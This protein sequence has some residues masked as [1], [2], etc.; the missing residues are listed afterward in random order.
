MRRF[1]F[2][3][4]FLGVFLIVGWPW[5]ALCAFA[6]LLIFPLFLEAIAFGVA[7]DA[8]SGSKLFTI[9]SVVLF[10]ALQRARMHIRPAYPYL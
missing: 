10:V 2:D 5:A 8:L 1:A 7:L 4:L 3:A 6:G 9:V